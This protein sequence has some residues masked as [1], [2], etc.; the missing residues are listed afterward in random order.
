MLAVDVPTLDG[1]QLNLE[2][3]GSVDLNPARVRLK[4]LD[5]APL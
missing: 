2:P 4:T 5:I 1:S 3:A